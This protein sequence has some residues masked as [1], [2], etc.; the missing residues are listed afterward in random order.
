MISMIVGYIAADRPPLVYVYYYSITPSIKPGRRGGTPAVDL[1]GEQRNTLILGAWEERAAAWY[2][3]EFRCTGFRA[4]SFRRECSR[5]DTFDLTLRSKIHN[6]IMTRRWYRSRFVSPNV[7]FFFSLRAREGACQNYIPEK[8]DE[9]YGKS[10]L[11]LCCRRNDAWWATCVW[12]VDRLILLV[13][14]LCDNP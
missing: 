5:I 7:Y 8:N 14:Q 1:S 2:N 13:F 12:C 3:T 10:W 11:V 4:S 6:A 9:T